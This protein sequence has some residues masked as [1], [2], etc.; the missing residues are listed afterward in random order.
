MVDIGSQGCSVGPQEILCNTNGWSVLD[1]ND[2]TFITNSCNNYNNCTDTLIQ[3][4]CYV[5]RIWLGN[6]NGTIFNSNYN[7]DAFSITV[8]GHG[9]NDI[10]CRE[11]R[12]SGYSAR[13]IAITDVVSYTPDTNI[14][15]INKIEIIVNGNNINSYTILFEDDI[16]FSNVNF[17]NSGGFTDGSFGFWSYFTS[18][19][20]YSIK[21]EEITPSCVPTSVPSFILFIFDHFMCL[22]VLFMPFV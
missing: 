1:G 17:T 14:G 18:V 8:Y 3:D 10:W 12:P 20:I 22:L 7:Y 19:T 13:A 9:G 21:L 16:I 2:W 15:D 11:I 6:S 5:S 4:G